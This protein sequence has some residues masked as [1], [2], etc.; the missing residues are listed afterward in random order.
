MKKLKLLLK[1]S[2]YVL[3]EPIAEVAFIIIALSVAVGV[4][5]G[6]SLIENIDVIL[7]NIM[8]FLFIV[9]GLLLAIFAAVS[10]ADKYKEFMKEEEL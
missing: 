5:Y 7:E 4:S 8:I 3:R 9:G 1:A 6:L 2:W 10:I